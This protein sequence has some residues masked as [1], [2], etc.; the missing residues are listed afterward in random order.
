MKSA[1]FLLTALMKECVNVNLEPQ[2]GAVTHAYL[3]TPGEE[4]ELAAQVGRSHMVT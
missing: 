3:D 1:V 4:A 2:V